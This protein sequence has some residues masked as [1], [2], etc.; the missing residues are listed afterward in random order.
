M[1]AKKFEEKVRSW[2]VFEIDAEI[3]SGKYSTVAQLAKKVEVN[4]RTI[5]RDIEFL[6]VMY[7]API[8]YST[9][10]RGYYYTDD[11]FFIKS[12]MLTEGELFSLAIFEPMLDQYRNTPLEKNLKII[13]EKIIRSLPN[14]VS[15]D[16][17][18]LNS[19]IS[20]V[21]DQPSKIDVTTF[22]TIIT[23]LQTKKA[24]SFDF[25][26][27]NGDID[28][29]RMMD[30]YHAICHRGNWYILGF[31]HEKKEMRVFSF[32]RIKKVVITNKVF[33][34]PSDFNPN[35][36]FDK[37]MGIW[38]SRRTPYTVEFLFDNE[39]RTFALERQ[40]HETQEITENEDGSVLVKFTTTQLP[41]VL[42]W[43]LSQG[44]TV[45]VLNP[46]ELVKMV[47]EEVE[48]I[49]KKYK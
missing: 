8:E 1:K 43:V 42:R 5:Q 37:Q 16:T 6:R 13:F 32:S 21:T 29:N 15:V 39:V 31:S 14:N 48:M 24:L 11:N 17:G 46:P 10:H 49:G 38:A 4:P 9:T 30:P 27:L 18:F 22:N 2:R 33:D 23:A 28:R 34:I 47:R 36:F 19:H 7:D 45:K 41:D 44:R 25:L 20:F 26:R 35:D 12:V 3:R 40:W